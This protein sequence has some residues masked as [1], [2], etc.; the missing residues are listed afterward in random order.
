MAVA[1]ARPISAV[2]RRSC[3]VAP[4]LAWTATPCRTA[5]RK[6]AAWGRSKRSSKSCA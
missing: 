5:Q 2:A 4:S 1:A 6:R 3:A